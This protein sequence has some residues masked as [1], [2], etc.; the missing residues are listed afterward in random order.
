M[1][2]SRKRSRSSGAAKK[3]WA[4]APGSARPVVSMMIQSNDS[5]PEERRGEILQS[6]HQVGADRAA[7]ATVGQLDDAATAARN[8]LTVD[9][10]GAELVFNDG[11]TQTL[12]MIQQRVEDGGLASPEKARQQGDRG[13]CAIGLVH[14]ASRKARQPTCH[15]A[16]PGPARVATGSGS[17]TASRAPGAV[18]R[19]LT[20]AEKLD[21]AHHRQL[22]MRGTHMGT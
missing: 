18:T 10:D 3:V 6:A 15:R 22:G 19:F 4:T 17:T 5:S 21:F 20:I 8:E 13:R 1:P 2:S 16:F 7:D 12:G 9:V 11:E 14:A